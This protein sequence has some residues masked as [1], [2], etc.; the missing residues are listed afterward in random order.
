[1]AVGMV[2]L[3][4]AWSADMLENRK[5]VMRVENLDWMKAV[6]L[7]A[8]LVAWWVVLMVVLLV[9]TLVE[10]MVAVLVG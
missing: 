9:L 4:V 10:R 5:V 1:M 8:N 7:A 3:K 2:V 6:H